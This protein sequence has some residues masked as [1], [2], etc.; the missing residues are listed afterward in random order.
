M[1]G[2]KLSDAITSPKSTML[3]ESFFLFDRSKIFSDLGAGL[4]I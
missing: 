3:T 2:R 4:G 1:A